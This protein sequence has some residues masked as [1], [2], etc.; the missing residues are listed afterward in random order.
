MAK[1][2]KQ[3]SNQPTQD[4]QW[5]T[6]K[7]ASE[8]LGIHY[9]TLRAW[10]DRGEIAVFRTPGGHRRFSLADL[11]RFL[12]AR[13]G[14]AI[15]SDADAFVSDLV[16]RVRQEIERIPQEQMQ[17]RYALDDSA[18]AVRNQRGRELFALA[19]SFVIK[20]QQRVRILDEGRKLGAEYGREAA[21]SRVSLKDTGRAVQFFRSQLVAFLHA[22]A[23]AEG[24][25]A[26]DVRAQQLVDQF[27]DEVLYAVLSG[28]EE[29]LDQV[30]R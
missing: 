2:A 12:E 9:T 21:A 25:D 22:G 29:V 23:S 15:V 27:I 17:W 3:A 13:T 1:M 20:P 7:E 28:Y 24:L 18:R 19:V 4:H 30:S 10:A 6:L 5:L 14:K 16:G 8:L 11:R 26:D